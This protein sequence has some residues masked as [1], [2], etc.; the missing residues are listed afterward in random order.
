MENI[1]PREKWLYDD[2]G[3]MNWMGWILADHSAYLEHEQRQHQARPVMPE[4]TAQ[5]ITESLR[6]SWENRVAVTI[7]LNIL[8]Q[9]T[10][11]PVMVGTVVGFNHDQTYLRLS[12]GTLKTVQLRTIRAVTLGRNEKWWLHANPI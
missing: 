5:Q 9:E 4:M 3:M 10:Y 8:N 11:V 12:D 2:R 1:V 6:V 7:Q